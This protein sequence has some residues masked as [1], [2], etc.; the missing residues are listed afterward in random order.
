MNY[1]SPQQYRGSIYQVNSFFYWFRKLRINIPNDRKVTLLDGGCGDGVIPEQLLHN[2]ASLHITGFDASEKQVL[3]AIER[4]KEF[5]NRSDF[6]VETFDSISPAFQRHRKEPVD[7]VIANYSLHLTPSM[8]SAIQNL[9]NCLKPGG[10][11]L[12]IMP[13]TVPFA[14]LIYHDGMKDVRFA[15]YL[16]QMKDKIDDD[17]PNG[18]KFWKEENLKWMAPSKVRGLSQIAVSS[19]LVPLSTFSAMRHSIMKE[20]DLRPIVTGV[21][22]FTLLIPEELRE[23]FQEFSIKACKRANLP[24]KQSDGSIRYSSYEELVL[25]ARKL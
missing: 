6:L 8:E 12:A 5:K 20:E 9:T 18:L 7:L 2:N 15:K 14:S 13:I 23:D 19:G 1:F 24:I 22:P 4:C 10:E 21:N 25:H 16:V 17:H 11:L 3:G